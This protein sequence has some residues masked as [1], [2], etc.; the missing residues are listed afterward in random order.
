M[1]RMFSVAIILLVTTVCWA[2]NNGSSAP[3]NASPNA[4]M[5]S[6]QAPAAGQESNRAVV[7]PVQLAKSIDSRKVKQGD[8]VEAKITTELRTGDGTV[9]PRG[10]KV[11]GHVTEASARAKGDASS[12]LGIAFDKIS[13]KSG[14]ELPL[15]ASIQ[16]IG[17]P[18]NYGPSATEMGN[19]SNM[20]S[21]GTSAPMG[22][23]NSPSGMGTTRPTFPSSNSPN[24]GTEPAGSKPDHQSSPELTPQSTGVVGLYDLQLEQGSILASSGKEVKLDAGSEILLRVQNQ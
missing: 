22:G 3:Q 4:S 20:P 24:S 15:K 21:A 19:P 1:K 2:Q 17:P 9:I 11:T 13:L 6:Q 14:K 7:I 10:S 8:P 5:P 18:P 16:A 23:T 12:Q